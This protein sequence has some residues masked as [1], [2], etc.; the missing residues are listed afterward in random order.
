MILIIIMLICLWRI[1]TDSFCNPNRTKSCSGGISLSEMINRVFQSDCT[2]RQ[3][4]VTKVDC[5]EFFPIR[6]AEV[7]A[8][9]LSNGVAG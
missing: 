4:I 8:A 2:L 1:I 6:F 5:F 3:S 9:F 7:L